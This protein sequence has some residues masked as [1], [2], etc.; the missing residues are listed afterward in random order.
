MAGVIGRWW[1]TSECDRLGELEMSCSCIAPDF[2][3]RDSNGHNKVASS[4]NNF[5]Y[6]L[7]RSVACVTILPGLEPG[8]W[9]L[10]Y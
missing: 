2:S 6:V 9:P 8:C 7:A 5:S 10:P 4:T 1:S 3:S